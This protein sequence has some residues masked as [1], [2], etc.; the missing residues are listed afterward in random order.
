EL[1]LWLIGLGVEPIWNPP[2]QPTGNPK[3]E[4]SN[5]LTQQWGEP[6][7]C[8]SLSQLARGLNRVG[9]IQRA[10]YPALHGQTRL[11][12]FPQLATPRRGYRVG[13]EGALWDLARVDAFLSRGCWRRRADRNGVI[14]LYGHS[15]AVGRGSA[16]Q[17]LGVQFDGPSRCWLISDQRGLVVK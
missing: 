1:A 11:A 6:Q 9:H 3:V 7:A 8:A 5:G 4:R 16:H 2:A 17:E 14:S 13:Q 15:R 10:E 12:V